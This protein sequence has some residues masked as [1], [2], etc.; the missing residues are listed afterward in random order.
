[1]VKKKNK[2]QLKYIYKLMKN[3]LKTKQKKKTNLSFLKKKKNLGTTLKTI[4][5]FGQLLQVWMIS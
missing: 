4:V 3:K 5:C 2:Q 1:M